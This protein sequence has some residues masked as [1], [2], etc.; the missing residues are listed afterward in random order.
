M[1]RRA[2]VLAAILLTAGYAVVWYAGRSAHDP[3]RPGAPAH[4][5][6]PPRALDPL[7]PAIL[8]E[9]GTF[10]GGGGDLPD[11]V[12]RGPYAVYDEM[13]T[14]LKTVAG[15]WIQRHEV[16]N[17]EY[18]RFD[19]GHVFPAGDERHPVANVTWEEAMAYAASLGGR[20]PTEREWEFAARG[21]ESRKYPWGDAEPT[22]QRAHFRGCEPESTLP[23]M[24]RPAGAT[25][26]GVHDLAGNVWE[27]V[28]PSWHVPGKTP[29][30]DEARRMRG[31][32][33][34]EEPFF[35]RASNRNN[36][37]FQGFRAPSVG[38][39]VVWP[40]ETSR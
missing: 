33:Y 24:S 26:E 13:G 11:T 25:P 20:L 18:R 37:F 15:F 38:F 28:M 12:E 27:W 6:P 39:R 30:N 31:G 10:W 14:S 32:S 8:I 3:A 40:I 4:P 29:V 5:T 1:T 9:A 16:T 23:V 35:L 34:L 7:N 21:T 22:C 2:A 17:A 36:D 19:P